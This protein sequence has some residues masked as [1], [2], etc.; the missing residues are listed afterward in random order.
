MRRLETLRSVALSI[1]VSTALLLLTACATLP[2]ATQPDVAAA[3]SSVPRWQQEYAELAKYGKVYR[4]DAARSVVRIYA[5]RA[6][7]AAR[8]GH[9]HVLNA[10][11]FSGWVY[12]PQEQLADAR[13]DLEFRLDTLQ[14]DNPEERARLGAA[15]AST[16]SPGALQ[17]TREHMLGEDNLAAQRYPFLRIRSLQISG[18]L[19]KLALK[20]QLSLHGQSRE[21]WLPL[22]VSRDQGQLH[23]RGAMVL[24]QTDF[25]VRPYSV[26][27]GFLAVQ[28]ELVIEFA[29][30]GE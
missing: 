24:R 20:I 17:R 28:D 5:F 21:M 1:L 15:F 25:G 16:L 9:N 8:L 2:A 13:V 19:P 23:V 14:L 27:G 7:T 6:G 29:L 26:L 12:L 30:Q 3:I 22:E 18:E 11:Q 4:L 10:P